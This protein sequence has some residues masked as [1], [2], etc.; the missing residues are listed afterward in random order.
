LPNLSTVCVDNGEENI[1]YFIPQTTQV[2]GGQNCD[3]LLGISSNNMEDT[4]ALYPNPVNQ[5]LHLET[6]TAY[7]FQ[8][9]QLYN[10]LG[11]LV[12]MLSTPEFNSSMVINVSALLAG[13]YFIEIN[14]NQGKTTKKFVKI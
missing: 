10:S 12:K 7:S 3:I 9:I 6:K 4:I 1:L 8:S 11:Q 2:F 14:S 5:E 13:T